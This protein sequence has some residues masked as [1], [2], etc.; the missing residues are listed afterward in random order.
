[1][2]P[3]GDEGIPAGVDLS[4]VS[5]T[6]A[7]HL[8]FANDQQL[9]NDG[10]SVVEQHGSV[11]THIPMRTCV[12]CRACVNKADLVRLVISGEQLIVDASG[13]HPGRGAY[14]HPSKECLDKALKRRAF[15]RALR[16]NGPINIHDV[17]EQLM[18]T[19]LADRSGAVG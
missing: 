14:V 6:F 19:S 11:G 17:S 2:T 13:S 3:V 15:P 7:E 12:G 18:L 8:T 10:R 5:E 16:W 1:M 9:A 4:A